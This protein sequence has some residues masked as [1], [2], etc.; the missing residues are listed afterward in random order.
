MNTLNYHK[1]SFLDRFRLNEGID[2]LKS[3]YHYLVKFNTNKAANLIND[4]KLHFCTLFV[5]QPVIKG[6]NYS[7]YLN[8][9]NESALEFI[10]DMLEKD[11]SNK[12]NSEN[13]HKQP[14]YSVLKWILETGWLDDGLNNKY[15]EILDKS[16]IL[17]T[18]KY[19]DI[20]IINIIVEII[21]SRHR[22][23]LYIHD[24][25]WALFES[26]SI[27]SLIITAQRLHSK[28]WRDVKLACKLLGFIPGIDIE[29]NKNR[30]KPYLVFLNWIE[31]NSS[32]LNYTGEGFQQTPT[33]E[34]YAVSLEA[35][36]LCKI[37]AMDNPKPLRLLNEESK[38]L[39]IFK[40]LDKN[41]RILLSRFSFYLFRQNYHEWI[42]WINYPVEKQ[43]RIAK[44]MGGEL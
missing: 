15:D 31:E 35:K 34:P 42:R 11:V 23:G 39:E 5:L 1:L 19:N 33:P 14:N 13:I 16:A 43:I 9:Q 12:K 24:M 2:K 8:S 30:V 36:Y 3:H 20:S 27:Q 4:K 18:K 22:K 28:Q 26:R 17:L 37:S 21:F 40:I 44:T 38:R 6:T 10:T 7:E 25:V 41:T 32:F 29:F